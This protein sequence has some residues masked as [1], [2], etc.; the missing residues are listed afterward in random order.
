MTTAADIIVPALELVGILGAG[1]ER[2]G[3]PVST[4]ASDI[5]IPALEL[6]GVLGAGIPHSGISV[7]ASASD[8]ITQALELVGV[9]GA[10]EIVT[11][12]D[13]TTCLRVLNAIINAW[14]T[15]RLVTLSPFPTWVSSASIP[16]GY[17]RALVYSLAVELYVTYNRPSDPEVIKI[18]DDARQRIKK[19]GVTDA[20]KTICLAALNNIVGTWG[21]K[22]IAPISRFADWGT[23]GNS[24]QPSYVRA[25]TYALAV[26]LA[27]YY[28]LQI[29]PTVAQIAVDSLADAQRKTALAADQD[30][31]LRALNNLLDSWDTERLSI[32][33]VQDIVKKGF[34]GATL[35]IGEGGQLNVPRPVRLEDRCFIR[36]NN[37]D[38]P[39]RVIDGQ[40]Y[41]EITL[42]SLNTTF[43]QVIY[44][45][46]QY[47]IATAYLW[48]VAS[49]AVDVHLRLRQ[50]LDGFCRYASDE[51]DFPPGYRRA[52]VYSL[53][54]ELYSVYNR[55]V[56]RNVAVI[57][58]KSRRNIK[59]INSPNVELKMPA[60]LL[61]RRASGINAAPLF[62]STNAVSGP[63][64]QQTDG[65]IYAMQDGV[66][67]DITD[68]II[69]P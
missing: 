39:L 1:I 15:E 22:R 64:V 19:K 63:M 43:P 59:R 66:W 49:M 62:S 45:D 28:G 6:S 42:K 20:D 40:T 30:V 61:S 51:I 24:L 48:P 31:C 58:S 38:Y 37:V 21:S 57:A 47:P 16:P 55:P 23:T 36:L 11:D 67:V 14:E 60:E 4:L 2:D 10:G 65:R 53:A 3:V 34:T 32:F 54:E 7:S 12:N 13:K 27:G 33:T 69:E 41:S 8:I 68:R 50:Q 35:T 17:R 26:D 18:A 46:A 5:I 25:L 56:D 44:L 52:L 9:L 29:A